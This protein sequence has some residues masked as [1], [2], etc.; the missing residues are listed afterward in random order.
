MAAGLAC[1]LATA[2]GD[3]SQESTSDSTSTTTTESGTP[4][5]GP[6][7]G[8]GSGAG[9]DTGPAGGSPTSGSGGSSDVGGGGGGPPVDPQFPVGHPRI[10]L[11]PIKKAALTAAMAEPTATALRFRDFVDRGVSGGDAYEFHGWHA[12]LVSQLTSDASYCVA[13]VD[14]VD[15]MVASEEA[16]IQG[17]GTPEVAYDSYLYVGDMVGDAALVMDWCF[18]AVTAEQSARWTAWANQAVWNV[19]NHESAEWN[20]TAAPW[21]G[22]SIDDP[23]NNYY[24]S[25]LRATMLL[26]LATYHESDEAPGWVDHFR[27]TKIE[28]QLVPI[29]EAQLEGGGSREGTGYGVSMKELFRLY[30]QWEQSTGERIAS[31]TPHARQSIAYMIHAVMPTRDRL[32][33]IG[34]HARD[35]TAA[36]FDYHRDY[37]LVD[38][39]LYPDDEVTLASRSMLAAS[40]VPEMGQGFMTF[41][42]FLH[43]PSGLPTAAESTL[44]PAYHAIGTGHVFARTSW[45]ED[46]TWLG[47]ISGPYTQSH[48]HHDQGSFLLHRGDHL[49]YDANVE[50]HSGIR[51]EEEMHNLVR[52]VRSG[53]TVPQRAEQQPSNTLA[54][55]DDPTF[56]YFATDAAPVYA[57]ETITAVVREILW[58]KPGILVIRDRIAAGGTTAVFQLNVPSQP[59]VNGASASA[60]E[61]D[62]F[63]VEP[64][65]ASLD[66]VDWAASPPDD[67]TMNGGYRID[68]PHDGG[69]GERV[70]VTVLSIGG[71]ATGAT[72]DGNDVTID[73]AGGG[74]AHVSFEEGAIGG[75]FDAGEL[76]DT[77]G[78][79]IEAWPLLAE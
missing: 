26:G 54:L 72:G 24:Y 62:L 70:F 77:F 38:G 32:A 61:L 27:T 76:G 48:A 19:W 45:D 14:L 44:Y 4:S 52:L 23:S 13:A 65:A 78:P 46:A 79:G 47:F 7:Q 60:G 74:E 22:W 3:D 12:A 55:A 39:A 29:F 6:G 8:P 67:D 35:S 28:E 37:L 57:D 73:L 50:S 31:L 64:A 1:V 17:G 75:S 63:V 20:G 42:D 41:S 9:G 15:A 30:E 58:I 59:D 5:S 56:S 21:T 2:C 11:N 68:V 51:Q 25:F 10:Y 69:A 53:E 40:T 66:V 34:D 36:L 43:D 71:A 49:A 33:P 18:E 16:I